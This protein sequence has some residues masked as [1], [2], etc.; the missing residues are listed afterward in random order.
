[1]NKEWLEQFEEHLRELHSGGWDR[2][3]SIP[4]KNA[5]AEFDRWLSAL[6][7]RTTRQENT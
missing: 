4:G 2:A 5:E 7:A 1:M 6:G 3:E